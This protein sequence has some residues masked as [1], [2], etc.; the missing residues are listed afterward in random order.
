MIIHI[1][2]YIGKI[3]V[4]SGGFQSHGGIPYHPKHDI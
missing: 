3:P 4:I 2:I 1:Y